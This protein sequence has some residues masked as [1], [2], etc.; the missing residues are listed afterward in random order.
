[1]VSRRGSMSLISEQEGGLL[2]SQAVAKSYANKQSNVYGM[3]QV[4][5]SSILAIEL[6]KSTQMDMTAWV[7]SGTREEVGI[8]MDYTDPEF[9]PELSKS[10]LIMH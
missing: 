9:V 3:I 7:R 8:I 2:G 5:Y 6:N 1:M 10:P 4:M